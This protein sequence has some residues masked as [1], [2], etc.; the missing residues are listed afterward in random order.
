MV[1]QLAL[2]QLVNFSSLTMVCWVSFGF[3]RHT[4][5]QT[6]TSYDSYYLFLIHVSFTILI[7]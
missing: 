5:T 1:S 3:K 4:H 7:I 2:F 6:H